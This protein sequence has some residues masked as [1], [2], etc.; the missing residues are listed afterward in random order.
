MDWVTTL[1]PAGDRSYNAC[2][3]LVDKYRKTPIF[4]PCH[5]DD[6]AM[7]AAIMIWN[8]AISH[9][10]LFQN[11]ISDR[12][13]KFT[14][15]LWTNFHN[16]FGTKFSFSTAYHPQTDGL[17]ER[18]IQTLEDMIRR[19]CTYALEFKDSDGFTL[20][21]CKLISA[22]ELAYK[23]SIHSSTGKTPEMLEKGW[24]PRIPYDTLKKDFVDIHS[25]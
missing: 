9:K 20:D 23:T 6:T 25:T 19:C 24:N 2:L 7:D 3:G 16:L 8:K 4:L 21:W 15:A 22:L 18:M 17:A 1:P 12:D 11:I 14:S 5:K 13:P 10:G